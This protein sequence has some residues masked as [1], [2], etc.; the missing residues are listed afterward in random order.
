MRT[1]LARALLV[2]LDYGVSMHTAWLAWSRGE[3]ETRFAGRKARM[4]S[5]RTW[6]G[7]WAL[8]GMVLV[9]CA[10]R[11]HVDVPSVTIALADARSSGRPVMSG[12]MS[13]GMSGDN[14]TD[15]LHGV[16]VA[17]PFRWLEEGE[18]PRVREWTEQQNATT[19]EYLGRVAGRDRLKAEIQQL[20]AIGFVGSPVV[21]LGATSALYL[22]TKREGSQN[23]PTLYVREGI[24]G[25]DRPLIET[26]ALSADGTTAL[27]WWYPSWEGEKV[28][29]GRSESGSEES[30]LLIRD[31][32]TGKDLPDRID[33]T[34]HAAVAWL[35]DGKG[36]YYSRYPE[37]GSVPAGEE[38]YFCKIFFHAIGGDPANDPLVFGEGRDKADIPVVALS[39]DGRWLVVYVHMGWDKSEVYLLDRS[40]SGA[41]WV[42]VAVKRSA[43]FQPYLRNNRM[44]I[45]TNDGAP[46][47]A[48]YAVDYEYP[49]RDRWHEILP[50]RHDVLDGVTLSKSEILATFLHGASTQIERFTLEGQS[51][52]VVNLPTIGTAETS[53]A[54]NGDDAFVSFTSYATPMQV[55]HLD[56][57]KSSTLTPWDGLRATFGTGDIEVTRLT[58][59]SKDGTRVPMF[60]VAKK[61]WAHD[62]SNPTV[63]YGYGGFNV[64]QTPSFSARALTIV[65][66][67]GVWVT[68]ILRGGGEF[69]EDWHRAGMLGQKQNVF[70][71]YVA[72]AEAL[73]AAKIT[74]PER[75][76]AMGGSN[77]GLLVAAAVTQRPELFRAGASLVPLTD[78]I[79][80]PR[81]RIAKLWVP[82]Y[83]D[84]ESEEAFRWLYAYSPYHHV[85]D[86][87]RYP[88][89]LFTTAESDSRVD[90]MHARKMAARMQE[91][92]NDRSRPILLRVE[93]KAGHG[94]GK[95]VSKLADELAD[96]LAFILHELGG[97]VR[98][99]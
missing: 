20:L 10:E 79:R 18:A 88:A 51:K 25:S 99:H 70:D 92:Q 5:R 9:G 31:T 74:S 21:R 34:R 80:Y 3:G 64:N 97:E 8:V 46:T 86:G 87:V 52:G 44:Y 55:H 41:S 7:L 59:T 63:L 68:A 29:W 40:K 24:H 1:T 58:A 37:A 78:M 72:C 39:P 35:P 65:R 93:S 90:P 56:L 62:G 91:A 14:V 17:D 22:H 16:A 73:I 6:Y 98:T 75:L 49:Q 30:V 61:G 69:G 76:A 84:P 53:A 26:S 42:E 27:D 50:A 67:G 38:K 23:Q 45:V 11:A 94:A 19:R 15:T 36:F 32:K 81:F 2:Q 28:A 4:Y 47:Y 33:R 66:N 48:L 71:D 82:E 12:G 85:R 43:I 57:R 54:W 13:G 89:M 60:V 83:G 95:P 77:G 96:E